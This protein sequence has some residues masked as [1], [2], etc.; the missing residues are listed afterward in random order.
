MPLAAFQGYLEPIG[1]HVFRLYNQSLDK[2]KGPFLRRVD[3]VFVSPAL[4]R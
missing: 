3:A 2:R 1:Y 4:G